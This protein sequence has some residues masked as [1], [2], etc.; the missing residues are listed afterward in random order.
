MNRPRQNLLA[1]PALAGHQHRDIRAGDA[2]CERHRFVHVA[3]HDRI[4]LVEREFVGRPQRLAAVTLGAARV[5]FVQ[6]FDERTD[7]VRVAIDSTSFRPTRDTSI[8]WSSDAW[9]TYRSRAA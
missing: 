3:G 1:C 5:E 7:G 4:S 2:L 8:F 9:T 6:T